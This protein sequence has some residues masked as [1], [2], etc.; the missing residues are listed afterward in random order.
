M[1][2]QEAGLVNDIADIYALKKEDLLNLERMGEILAE[3]IIESIDA[4]REMPLSMFLRSLGIRNVGDHLSGVIARHAKTL[5]AL[6]TMSEEELIDIHEVG[7]EVARS[8]YSFF[9]TKETLGL[10]EKMLDRGLEIVKEEVQLSSELL[11]DKTLVVTG[12]MTAFSRKEME[13][14]ITE[15]GGRASGSVSKKTDYL[16]AGADP[17]SKLQKAEDL[18]V[19]VLSETEFLKMLGRS[20]NE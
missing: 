20:V 4:R 16:V 12:T 9:H 3:K 14:M 15:N 2:L 11:A 7:P 10:V 13:K 5:D 17:G 8:V 18:G 6:C 1:R 19:P